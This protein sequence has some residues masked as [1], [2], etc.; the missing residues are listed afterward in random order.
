[1][2]VLQKLETDATGNEFGQAE[3]LITNAISMS[4]MPI[5]NIHAY[6]L[7]PGRHVINLPKGIIMVAGFTATDL[8]IRDAKLNG[9]SNEVDWLFMK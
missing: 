8:K 2:P 3:A 4:N 1:M 7:N 5:V 9:G 6:H